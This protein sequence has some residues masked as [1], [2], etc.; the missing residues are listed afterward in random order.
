M[1]P[2][3]LMHSFP[4]FALFRGFY[5]HLDAFLFKF[6]PE[7]NPI[8]P[9]NNLQ[10][11]RT[12]SSRRQFRIRRLSDVIG[13][14]ASMCVCLWQHMRLGVISVAEGGARFAGLRCVVHFAT[15]CGESGRVEGQD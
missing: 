9:R 12:C 2:P 11:A 14:M 7:K 13:V 4:F 8:S 10:N 5:P 15:D 1:S 6:P 3:G